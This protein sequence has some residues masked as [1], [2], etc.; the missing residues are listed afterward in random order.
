MKAAA[1]VWCWVAAG[2]VHVRGVVGAAARAQGSGEGVRRDERGA[3]IS[4]YLVANWHRDPQEAIEDG[5]RFWRTLRFGDVF[6]PLMAL[7]GAARFMRYVG[8]FSTQP[9]S[10]PALG[11]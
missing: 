5:L 9:A 4:A 1:W 8:E 3:L 7:G 2:R 6:A 11:P 10:R